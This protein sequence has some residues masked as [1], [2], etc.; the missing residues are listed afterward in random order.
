[1]GIFA[2]MR[3]RKRRRHVSAVFVEILSAH[4]AQGGS[5]FD[6]FMPSME[7]PVQ[8]NKEHQCWAVPVVGELADG[9]VRVAAGLRISFASGRGGAVNEEA[10]LVW[11]ISPGLW[12]VT[13]D[14]ADR[15]DPLRGFVIREEEV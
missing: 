2:R 13:F 4:L 11:E 6:L 15:D 9:L 8:W 14:I 7:D 3:E 5:V 10:E 1:M 12:E